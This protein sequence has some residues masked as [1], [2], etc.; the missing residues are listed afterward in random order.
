MARYARKTQRALHEWDTLIM[1]LDIMI[2]SNIGTKQVALGV[3]LRFMKYTRTIRQLT[4]INRQK[5]VVAGSHIIGN[6]NK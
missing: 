6:L 2:Y 3:V 5:F 4:T 1:S